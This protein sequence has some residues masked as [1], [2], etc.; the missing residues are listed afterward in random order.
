MRII[1]MSEVSDL[2][3]IC[4]SLCLR[5]G[6]INGH[7]FAWGGETGRKDLLAIMPYD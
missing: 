7:E 2:L 6:D 4:C 5:L 1:G 3:C